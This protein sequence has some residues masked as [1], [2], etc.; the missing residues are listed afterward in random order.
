[1]NGWIDD[2]SDHVLKFGMKDPDSALSN[3]TVLGVCLC[4]HGRQGS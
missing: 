3:S 4:S 1:M 2:Q